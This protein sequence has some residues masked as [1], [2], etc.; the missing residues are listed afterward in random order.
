RRLFDVVRHLCAD[1]SSVV[2][3]SHRL[4]EAMEICDR[5]VILRDGETVANLPNNE[6]LTKREIVRHMIGS[7]VADEFPHQT[8]TPGAEVLEVRDL[9]FL[10]N[11]GRPIDGVSFSVRAGEI[12]GI[13]GLVGVGK[14]EL[15]QAIT[16]LQS[17]SRGE[18]LVDGT[19]R[20][21]SSPV[22]AVRAGIGY[23]TEDRRGEGLV[24]SMKSLYN[25]TLTAFD[26][27]ARFLSI[28]RSRE[29]N[30][31]VA[32]TEKLNMKPQYA[33]M[34][35]GKLSG[36]NQQKVV[37]IRRLIGDSRV[38]VL[39]E[40]T[41]GIDVGAKAGIAHLLSQLTQEG[42]GILILSSEP[43]EVLGMS[44]RV[45]VMTG[46]GLHGPFSRGELDYAGLMEIEFGAAEGA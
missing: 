27:I 8:G 13:T 20:E 37:L 31:G 2:F 44:D 16:G 24:L 40:P 46:N 3:I 22:A 4:E 23:V 25:M 18:I 33:Q 14:S 29:Q 26:K 11:Q 6:Q 41:K 15:A 1:G 30:L 5:F 10:N 9:H 32:Y 12:L 28:R 36:G 7:D 19:K 39:D 43:R 17:I 45:L 21:I 35:S 42:K 34:E 38:L